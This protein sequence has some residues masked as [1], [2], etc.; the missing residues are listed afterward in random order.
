MLRR[1]RATPALT[2]LLL[3]LLLAPSA[4]AQVDAQ[5]FKPAVTHDGFV[6]AEGTAVRHPD[7]R[8]DLG[9]WL[10]YAHNPLVA[11]DA[12]GDLSRSFVG[13]RLG[14]DAVVSASLLRRLALGASLPLY[15]LQSGDANPS[16]AGIGDLRLVPKLELLSDLESGVGLAL[17]AEVRVPTH[18]GD[19]SGGQ[20]SLELVPKIA[21][22]HRFLSGVRVGFNLG[23]AVRS[24]SR[25]LNVDSDDEL[26]Y[27]AALGYR[28]GG[29]S[30]KTEIGIELDG[31]IGLH[32]HDRE[33]LPL[34][35]LG[36]L[37]HDLSSEWQI[38][39]GPGIGVIAGYGVPT[40]R[41]FFGVRFTPTSH[42]QDGD[43]VSDAEDECPRDPEDRDGIEDADGC[44][45]EDPDFDH[46]GVADVFDKCP[47]AKETINGVD[48]E[49][50][51]PDSGDRRVTYED[52]HF[53]V[54]DTIRFRT[55][56]AEI[57]RES[58]PLL[59]QIALTLKANPEIEHMRVEGHT[60]DTG[61]RAFNMQL[62][63]ERAHSVRRYLIQ[64]GVNPQRLRVRSY[65]PDRPKDEGNDE[66]A[67]ARNRRVE[68]VLE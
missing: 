3:S 31:G 61:P 52:G 44:P 11:A 56:S 38:L 53:I 29:L 16:G 1:T 9:L 32:E 4:R 12:N 5:R 36:Y 49:D 54:L 7:D 10:N 21:L 18:S 60:D 24:T 46:D 15:V 20:R 40:L 6:N 2:G 45:E 65:G 25:F 59:D 19:F 50:G 35:A 27:A 58:H 23:V 42:D 41:G 17:L 34:E 14:F 67:R 48:D 13:E 66:K 30:G 51:C 62:S 64:R 37:S 26:A 33:E 68:F 28:L 8:W 55:G 63:E 47:D 39:G 43:G 22:E 57:D